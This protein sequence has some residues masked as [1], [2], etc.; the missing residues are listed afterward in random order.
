MCNINN[1]K[2]VKYKLILYVYTR[3]LFDVIKSYI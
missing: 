3:S 2:D 1:I